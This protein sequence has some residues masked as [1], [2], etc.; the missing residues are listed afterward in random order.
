MSPLNH[1]STAH[2]LAHP[3][4]L[5]KRGRGSKFWLP[6]LEGGSEKLKKGGGSMV[7]GQ[8][9]LREG[10][11]H[12]SYLMLSRFVI[13]AFRNYFTLYKIVLWICR[14][15]WLF[16]LFCYCVIVFF[17]ATIILWRK[18]ILSCLKKEPENTP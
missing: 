1:R 10:G 2:S 6:P 14:L 15:F 16:I 18:I 13:F 9:F 11:W 3:H 17:P 4:P 7:Q 12:C 5:F 8:V